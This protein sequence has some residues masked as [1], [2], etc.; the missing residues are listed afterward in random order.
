MH[1]YLYY[2]LYFS[3]VCKAWRQ[4]EFRSV[5]LFLVS[6]PS[7]VATISRRLKIIGLF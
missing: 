3:F 1:V 2:F 5:E 6:P 4:L 7:R